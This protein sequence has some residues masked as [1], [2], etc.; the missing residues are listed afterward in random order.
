[1]LTVTNCHPPANK[2]KWEE[3]KLD[4][5]KFTMLSSSGKIEELFV[6]LATLQKISLFF[7][8]SAFQDM[9]KESDKIRPFPFMAKRVITAFISCAE[10]SIPSKLSYRDLQHLYK[11]GDYFLSCKVQEVALSLMM[12]YLN[13][14]DQKEKKKAFGFLVEAAKSGS[15]IKKMK[16][17]QSSCFLAELRK[18][19]GEKKIVHPEL[20]FLIGEAFNRGIGGEKY[21]DKALMLFEKAAKK[22]HAKALLMLAKHYESQ[23]S[24]RIYYLKE[25]V[26][27]RSEEAVESLIEEFLLRGKNVFMEEPGGPIA[28]IKRLV[29]EGGKK[30]Y[31]LGRMYIEGLYALQDLKKGDLLLELAIS[32][33]VVE[34][35][36]YLG[37]RLFYKIETNELNLE[38]QG[39]AKAKALSLLLMS[40]EVEDPEVWY[41]LAKLLKE[42]NEEE[43]VAKLFL[44]AAEKNYVQAMVAIGMAFV[45]GQGVERDLAKAKEWFL[46]ANPRENPDAAIQLALLYQRNPD[47][48]DAEYSYL[49]LF[50]FAANK[51]SGFAYAMLGSLRLQGKYPSVSE[52]ENQREASRLFSQAEESED[53]HVLATV[54]VMYF[55]WDKIPFLSQKKQNEKMI[56]LFSV[57]TARGNAMGEC[58]LGVC[59]LYGRGVEKDVV[60][61]ASLLREA[62]EKNWAEAKSY[63]GWLYASEA[64]LDDFMTQQEQIQ[65]GVSLLSL[66]EKE[67]SKQAPFF[68]G[69]LFLQGKGV[70]K[71]PTR[72]ANLFVEGVKRGDISAQVEAGRMFLLGDIVEK[73]IE[74]AEEY[75]AMAAKQSNTE[76]LALL[77]RLLYVEKQ[78]S[79][80]A[81]PYLQAAVNQGDLSSISYL[82]DMYAKGLGQ[83][84]HEDDLICQYEI[85]RLSSLLESMEK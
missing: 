66:A 16:V 51:K 40:E 71:N 12:N 64:K 17:D 18:D 32:K 26:K 5:V 68:L 13:S 41:C 42:H 76:A 19:K 74:A 73:D 15:A 61:A 34:A 21:P 39:G 49:A 33:G 78:D 75:L 30:D 80:K 84:K 23:E 69:Q 55:L 4:Q 56:T 85:R 47:W 48:S 63:L 37:K 22:G 53:A 67:G 72:A 27:E 79:N 20:L 77:G 50:E 65:E 38:E 24:K 52:E 14:P 28:A 36:A 1:L 82:I 58:Y 29:P 43:K 60:K 9:Q 83:A 3:E 44:K 8:S 6:P 45:N 35:S 10:G 57:A 70:K 25:A 59:Y 31:Y 2:R 81:F 46:Q 7:A 62:K 54:G 11:L